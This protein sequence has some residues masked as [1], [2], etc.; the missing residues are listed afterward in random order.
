MSIGQFNKEQA[1]KQNVVINESGIYKGEITSAIEKAYDSG[2]ES[3]TFN[4]KADDDSTAKFMQI[5]TIKKDGTAA[6]GYNQVQSL[7]GLLE[8]RNA[9]PTSHDDNLNY[10]CFCNRKI[11]LGLQRVNTPGD[12]YPF[13]MNIVHFFD[14]NSLQ[15]YAEKT[16][17]QPAKT[18]DRKID[19]TT[20]TSKQGKQQQQNAPFNSANDDLPF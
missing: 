11:A 2:A 9:A 20:D 17:N 1:Q 8:I 3:I 7:M 19:D 6:F 14:Y 12:K 5:F 18:K 10:D 15:T 13:R 16:N 4:F